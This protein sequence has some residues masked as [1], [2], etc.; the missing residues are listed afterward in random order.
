MK[1]VILLLS[2]LA[3]TLVVVLL[4]SVSAS[5]AHFPPP[6]PAIDPIVST[7][8]L[9]GNLGAENLVI[10]DVR[11]PDEYAAGHIPGA[12]NKVGS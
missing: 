10:L 9:E 7:D 12:I 4:F 3:L 11:T 8:W 1:K 6:G 5:A 2:L